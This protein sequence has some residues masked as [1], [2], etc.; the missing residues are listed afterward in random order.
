M[1]YSYSAQY[2]TVN[3]TT[4]KKE[5]MLQDDD[6]AQIACFQRRNGWGW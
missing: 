4:A 6:L 5:Y 1:H 3:K 2:R